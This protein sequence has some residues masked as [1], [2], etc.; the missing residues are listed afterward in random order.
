MTRNVKLVNGVEVELTEQEMT[1]IQ[2]QRESEA[3]EKAEY[4]AKRKYKDDRRKELAPLDGEGL[5]AI[6]KSIDSL[7]AFLVVDLP[8]EFEQYM[9]DVTAIKTK[10]PKP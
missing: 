8:V 9:A 3:Q 6:R 1:A 5:D 4:L 2:S 7:A 10:F